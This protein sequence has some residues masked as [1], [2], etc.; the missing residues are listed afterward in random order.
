MQDDCIA[1]ALG[2]PE[3]KI[4]GQQEMENHFKV[5]VMYRRK[6]AICPCCG[7]VTNKVHDQR[8]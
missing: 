5:R 6:E 2:L 7:M 3:L 4:L 1:V 8:P